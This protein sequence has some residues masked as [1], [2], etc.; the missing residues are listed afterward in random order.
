MGGYITNVQ[1][2]DIPLK[3]TRSQLSTCGRK[4]EHARTCD[5]KLEVPE[6]QILNATQVFCEGGVDC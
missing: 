2:I 5:L 4:I 1:M 6:P 3:A